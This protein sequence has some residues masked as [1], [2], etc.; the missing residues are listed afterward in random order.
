[1]LQVPDSGGEDSDFYLKDRLKAQEM[2]MLQFLYNSEFHAALEHFEEKTAVHTEAR[3]YHKSVGISS[4]EMKL[5]LAA[6]SEKLHKKLIGEDYESYKALNKLETLW[7]ARRIETFHRYYFEKYVSSNNNLRNVMTLIRNEEHL[8]RANH[9]VYYSIEK[10]I[11]AREACL[12]H[13]R[14]LLKSIGSQDLYEHLQTLRDR[15]LERKRRQ[16]QKSYKV[17]G[18]PAKYNLD[19]RETKLERT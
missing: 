4:E 8:V 19:E 12:N 11:W 6:L 10:V 3:K 14:R 7:E 1:M 18:Y 5:W 13:L 2:D 15:E 16:E 9:H 17:Y